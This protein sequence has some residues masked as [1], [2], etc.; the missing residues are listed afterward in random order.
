MSLSIQHI[1]DHGASL[2][3]QTGSCAFNSTLS[4]KF[5]PN[6]TFTYKWVMGEA[7]NTACGGVPVGFHYSINPVKSPELNIEQSSILVIPHITDEYVEDG[8]WDDNYPLSKFL[9]PTIR[10]IFRVFICWFCQSSFC[11][12]NSGFTIASS[13]KLMIL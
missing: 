13:Q 9:H 6:E 8:I 4:R 7:A 12:C 3:I 5:A 10:L 1:L 2:E 11:F